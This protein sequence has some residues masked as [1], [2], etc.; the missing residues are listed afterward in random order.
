M[1]RRERIL[2]MLGGVLILAA[3]FFYYVYSPR[4][5]EY[6]QLSQQLSDRQAQLERME[7]TARQATQL[8]REYASLQEF[9]AS[10]ESKLPTEKEMPELLVRLERLT[11]SLGVNFQSIRPSPLEQVTGA[12]QG[13]PAGGHAQ[14]PAQASQGAPLYFKLPLKL[15]FNTNYSGLLRLSAALHDFPRLVI[16]RRLTV[17]PKTV[18]ELGVEV[19]VEAF[20]LPK[21]AR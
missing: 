2:L 14:A 8:E 9:I 5:A 19:D 16:V 17:T 4:Q 20:V 18:P 11:R 10:I 1:S 6:A 15:S 13:T 12:A 3:G 21:E 7:A